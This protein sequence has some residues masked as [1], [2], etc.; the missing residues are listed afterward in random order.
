ML[1]S[2]H[3]SRLTRSHSHRALVGLI[4]V[5]STLSLSLAC[6]RTS[7]GGGT[8]GA[9]NGSG[10]ANATGG[11][12]GGASGGASSGGSGGTASGGSG[13]TASACQAVHPNQT[14]CPAFFCE[15]YM[16]VRCQGESP[17][18]LFA[19]DDCPGES[20][21]WTKRITFSDGNSVL[22]CYYDGEHSSLVAARGTAATEVYCDGTASEVSWGAEVTDCPQSPLAPC[23]PPSPDPDGLGGAGPAFAPGSCDDG[24]G[25][26]LPCCPATPAPQDCTQ[27]P[28]STPGYGCTNGSCSCSCSSG[29]WLCAC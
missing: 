2:S 7:N 21:A 10:G 13:G 1:A 6:G 26:C 9:T 15:A 4:V 5:L 28:F 14:G 24:W 8:G 12:P 23:E 17:Y 16:Q 25:G 19:R 18:D 22:S 11:A 20:G 29:E 27:E 3:V